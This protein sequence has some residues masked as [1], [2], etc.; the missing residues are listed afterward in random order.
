MFAGIQPYGPV[1]LLN[2]TVSTLGRGASI[3]KIDTYL[4]SFAEGQEPK[5][6]IQ[7]NVAKV[8]GDVEIV[9]ALVT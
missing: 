6:M 3:C 5:A 2:G 9:E 8:R 1:E 4:G 7:D